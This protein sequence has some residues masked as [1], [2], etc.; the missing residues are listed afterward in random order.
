M[1]RHSANP[2]VL[3]PDPTKG[4]QSGKKEK[5]GRYFWKQCGERISHPTLKWIFFSPRV[6]T[7]IIAMC[8]L[9]EKKKKEKR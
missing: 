9:R 7:E 4:Q 2:P 8:N 3:F 5:I 1:R 6:G